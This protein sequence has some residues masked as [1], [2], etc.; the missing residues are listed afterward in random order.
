MMEAPRNRHRQF[1]FML[2]IGCWSE[3]VK[4]TFIAATSRKQHQTGAEPRMLLIALSGRTTG[5]SNRLAF[6]VDE[7]TADC[8]IFVTSRRRR[9]ARG[10]I[11]R[12][13][14][15]IGSSGFGPIHA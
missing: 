9:A 10:L 7:I 3:K 2:H 8:I 1:R 4:C 12:E 14:Q 13:R 6:P 15:D 5:T 11:K